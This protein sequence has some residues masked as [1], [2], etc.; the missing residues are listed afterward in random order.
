MRCAGAFEHHLLGASLGVALDVTENWRIALMTGST[1]FSTGQRGTVETSAFRQRFSFS[2]DLELLLDFT[3]RND[4]R[5][6]KLTLGYY[7]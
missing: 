7:F 3:W 4:Y 1:E 2:A 6:G 5:E